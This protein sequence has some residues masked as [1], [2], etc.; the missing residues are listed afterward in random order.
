LRRPSRGRRDVTFDLVDN[1]PHDGLACVGTVQDFLAS[2]L[3]DIRASQR[4]EAA[5]LTPPDTR[6]SPESLAHAPFRSWPA[7]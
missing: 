2:V 4:C 1:V 3:R 7:C 6:S 5:A